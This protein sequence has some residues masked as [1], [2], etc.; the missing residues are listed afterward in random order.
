MKTIK[1]EQKENTYAEFRVKD[2]VAHLNRT[3]Q[4]LTRLP[5]YLSEVRRDGIFG[6]VRF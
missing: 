1:T 5:D 4:L 6:I 2:T 3:S